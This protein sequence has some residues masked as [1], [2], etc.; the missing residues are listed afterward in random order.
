LECF[1]NGVLVILDSGQARLFYPFKTTI[2]SHDGL[3][4]RADTLT[5]Q[6]LSSLAIIDVRAI[7]FECFR[8]YRFGDSARIF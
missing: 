6:E 8:S 5:G 7:G 4:V 1:L 3:G 2:I